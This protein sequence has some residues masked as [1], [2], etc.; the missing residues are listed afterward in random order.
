MATTERNQ[1][2]RP[3]KV[4]VGDRVKVVEYNNFTANYYVGLEGRVTAIESK[5]GGRWIV[6]VKLDKDP[7]PKLEAML[8]GLPCLE[9]ELEVLSK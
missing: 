7:S 9:W 8:G 2:V 1:L 4:S 6:L 5:A 3:T